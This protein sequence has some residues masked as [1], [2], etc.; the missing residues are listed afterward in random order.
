VSPCERDKS[1]QAVVTAAMVEAGI[2]ALLGHCPDTAVGDRIDREMVE[3]IYRA[4]AEC[5][6]RDPGAL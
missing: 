5:R 3:E 2:E 6:A 1:N 4:M